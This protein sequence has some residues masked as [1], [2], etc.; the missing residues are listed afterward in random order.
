MKSNSN[1]EGILKK[2]GDVGPAPVANSNIV[3]FPLLLEREKTFLSNPLFQ[4]KK[5]KFVNELA[6]ENRVHEVGMHL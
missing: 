2:F 1:F 3:L 6:Y 4:K 5:K